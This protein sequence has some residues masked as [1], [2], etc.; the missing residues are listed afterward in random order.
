VSST[1]R[2]QRLAAELEVMRDLVKQSSVL[3]F[4]AEGEAPDRYAITLRGRGIKRVSSHADTIEY[5]DLHKCEIRLGYDFP[6]RAPEV[7]WLTPIFHPNVSYSGSVNLKECG[8]AWESGLTLG[9]VCER[10]WDL[11]RLAWMDLE[12]ATDASAKRWFGQHREL[13]L[14]LDARPLRDR[15]GPAPANVVRYEHGLPPS[16]SAGDGILY[17]GEDTPVPELPRRKPVRRPKDDDDILYI[18]DE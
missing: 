12:T 7:R 6:Q 2:K 1:D 17:I 8:L 4:E 15:A 9:V 5:G 18:G 10:I 13:A 14:P 16:T 11:A 3:E